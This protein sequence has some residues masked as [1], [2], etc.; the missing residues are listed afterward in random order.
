MGVRFRRDAGALD[1]EALK[2]LAEVAYRGRSLSIGSARARRLLQAGERLGMTAGD[3]ILLA[4]E[5][6]REIDELGEFVPAMEAVLD[7]FDSGQLVTGIREPLNLY[8]NR[9]DVA[10]LAVITC[11]QCRPSIPVRGTDQEPS[12][13]PDDAVAVTPAAPSLRSVPDEVTAASVQIS[14]AE[15]WPERTG[16]G[17]PKLTLPVLAWWPGLD[18]WEP[19]TLTASVTQSLAFTGENF[20]LL[21]EQPGDQAPARTH[22]VWLVARNDLSIDVP[23]FELRAA[24]W[25]MGDDDTHHFRFLVAS[26][27]D[28]FQELHD[29][30][31]TRWISRGSSPA[32]PEVFIEPMEA[33]PPRLSPIRG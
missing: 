32:G 24:T 6:L 17:F 2:R 4:T 22:A 20:T 19:M 1:E 33:A 18:S 12:R 16:D 28:W 8:L 5:T 11:E 3:T 27:S 13:P 15:N 29:F 14:G 31:A 30:L 26:S 9:S 23:V 21:I 25:E 7:K 10:A